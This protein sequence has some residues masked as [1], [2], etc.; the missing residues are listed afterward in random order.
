MVNWFRLKLRNDY[1]PQLRICQCE[2]AEFISDSSTTKDVPWNFLSRQWV[3]RAGIGHNTRGP[4]SE[5][6]LT[7]SFAFVVS[8]KLG[9]YASFLP[10]KALSSKLA[11]PGMRCEALT[12]DE[13]LFTP[14]Y[15]RC[16][17]E[18]P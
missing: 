2:P 15:G 7:N 11:D 3:K 16:L 10:P 14:E 13:K 1:E 18:P 17:F 5:E 12:P 9:Q 8:A 6:S 4:K